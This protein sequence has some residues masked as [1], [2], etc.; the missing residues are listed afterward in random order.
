MGYTYKKILND[1]QT[2][3][4]NWYR[5]WLNDGY[6]GVAQ[7]IT[8][9]KDDS[10]TTRFSGAKAKKIEE[11]HEFDNWLCLCPQQHQQP[12]KHTWNRVFSMERLQLSNHPQKYSNMR[13]H[14]Q[15]WPKPELWSSE[16]PPFTGTSFK[17]PF[18]MSS[19]HKMKYSVVSLCT[20]VSLITSA[21]LL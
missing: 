21:Q 6:R 14:L 10:V 17:L 15:R 1:F 4:K 7:Q 11:E 5:F 13:K 8:S 18:T 3:L 16:F 12:A 2:Q 20:Q 9:L 19:Q